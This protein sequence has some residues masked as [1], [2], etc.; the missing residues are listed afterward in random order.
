MYLPRSQ[1]EVS[2]GGL[3]GRSQGDVS[4]GGLSGTSQGDVSGGCL[5]RR[6]QGEVSGH[7]FGID[8]QKFGMTE[9]E[10][11]GLLIHLFMDEI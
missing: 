11:L 3:G 7:T 9:K 8:E 10:L 4:G 1:G 2:G 6:S 5:R